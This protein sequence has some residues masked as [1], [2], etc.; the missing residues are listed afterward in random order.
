ML[1]LITQNLFTP[2]KNT[3]VI[4]EYDPY[5]PEI[6]LWI[7]LLSRAVEDLKYSNLEG[8]TARRFF[9][10][11]GVPGEDFVRICTLIN[12][13]YT[14]VLTDI[15]AN[16]RKKLEKHMRAVKA[17][18]EGAGTKKFTPRDVGDGENI[19]RGLAIVTGKQYQ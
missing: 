9:F 19:E 18:N 14:S 10:Q 13:P 2:V 17:L 7:A 15:V 3:A 16:S 4:R 11:R 6:N 1:S 12:I 5:T 8:I